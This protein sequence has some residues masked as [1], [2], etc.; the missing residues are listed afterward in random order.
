MV[1]NAILR[2]GSTYKV[3]EKGKSFKDLKDIYVHLFEKKNLFGEL[4]IL[5]PFYCEVCTK[6]DFFICQKLLFPPWFQQCKS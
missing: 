1:Y 5:S 3:P 2:Q 6:N 4:N